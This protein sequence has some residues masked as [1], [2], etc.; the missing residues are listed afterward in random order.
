MFVFFAG[1]YILNK[2]YQK[3]K[4][5]FALT[6]QGANAKTSDLDTINK[7]INFIHT[8]QADRVI[9]SKL[10]YDISLTDNSGINIKS[11]SFSKEK[12]NLNIRGEAK[13]REELLKFKS[14]LE[15]ISYLSEII[16]PLQSLFKKDDISFDINANIESYDFGIK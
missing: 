14:A 1:N 11:L 10:I 3:T 12:K 13:T 16:F 15:K 2:H 4:D 6:N 5:S 9:W 7:K 8:I